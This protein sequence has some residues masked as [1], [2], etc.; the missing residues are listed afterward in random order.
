MVWSFCF[1]FVVLVKNDFFWSMKINCLGFF[2]LVFVL[3]GTM[4]E[5][6]GFK[7]SGLCNPCYGV[8]V[9]RFLNVNVYYRS[10]V[11]GVG[12][13]WCFVFVDFYDWDFELDSD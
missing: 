13:F 9:Y 12:V 2:W 5:N 8:N 7:F 11:I 3:L 1:S 6:I 10:D 4:V